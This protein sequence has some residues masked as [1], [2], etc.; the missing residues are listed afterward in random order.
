MY[1]K[2]IPLDLKQIPVDDIASCVEDYPDY[3][4]KHNNKMVVNNAQYHIVYDEVEAMETAI[5]IA[6]QPIETEYSGNS[7]Y[8]VCLQVD[9]P[10]EHS[11][12]NDKPSYYVSSCYKVVYDQPVGKTVVTDFTDSVSQEFLKDGT[13]TLRTFVN[14]YNR[15]EIED[16]EILVETEEFVNQLN[17]INH[18]EK[19][20]N[21]LYNKLKA[22]EKARENAIINF[23]AKIVALNTTIENLVNETE[24]AQKNT[25]IKEYLRVRLT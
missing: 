7:V 5:N 22:E 10:L 17:Y 6:N 20:K 3:F 18:L 14:K 15:G 19:T 24:R 23:S 1:G 13:L 16:D 11:L 9:T 25:N 4:V 8:V 2:I 21:D 12:K